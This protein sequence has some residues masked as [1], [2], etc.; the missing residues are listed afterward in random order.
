MIIPKSP[1]I[2]GVNPAD[3]H[4][5]Q[6]AKRG[7]AEYVMSRSELSRLAKNP[8]KWLEGEPE[9]KS[10]AMDWGSLIDCIVLTPEYFDARYAIT[11]EI[12]LGP[13]GEEKEWN[14]NAAYCKQWREQERAQG[15]EPVKPKIASEAQLAAHRLRENPI[16]AEFLAGAKTQAKCEVNYEDEDTGLVITLVGLLDIVPDIDG[17]YGNVLGD[18]KTT[19]DASERAWER[20]VWSY[21]YHVQAAIYLDMFNACSGEAREGFAHVIQ[22]SSK[23]Y[24]VARRVLSADYIAI[25]RDT[26]REQLR[27]Y[28]RCLSE[29][30]WPDYDDEQGNGSVIIDGFRLVNPP[31]YAFKP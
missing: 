4:K 24:A 26:Y 22:E 10:D 3:Y 29:G 13:K 9:E 20:T 17:R 23:P 2:Y 6:K 1:V 28:C 16:I 14:W 30:Y 19:D 25:G 12:Y 18:L 11:P 8:A 27:K 5:P 31:A 7:E 21:G 15:R